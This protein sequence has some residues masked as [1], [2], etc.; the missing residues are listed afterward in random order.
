MKEITPEP[1]PIKMIFPHEKAEALIDAGISPEQVTALVRWSDG[2]K[3]FGI[4]KT[5]GKLRVLS[6]LFDLESKPEKHEI[7]PLPDELNDFTTISELS[8]LN[9][10]KQKSKHALQDWESTKF[11]N[12]ELRMDFKDTASKLDESLSQ[13]VTRMMGDKELRFQLLDVL[14]VRGMLP[15]IRSNFISGKE[16]THVAEKEE[17]QCHQNARPLCSRS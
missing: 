1:E 3:S 13:E 10:P 12:N 5:D 8:V 4:T 2:F 9:E 15:L 7:K 6:I 16:A 14:V 17:L 11:Q